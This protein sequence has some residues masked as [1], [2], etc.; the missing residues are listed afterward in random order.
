MIKE[1][2]DI[3]NIDGQLFEVKVVPKSCRQLPQHL[4]LT[5]FQFFPMENQDNQFLLLNLLKIISAVQASRYQN[6]L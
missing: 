2:I 3:E 1:R 5:V 6:F 4:I